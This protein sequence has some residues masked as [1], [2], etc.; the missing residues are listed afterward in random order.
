MKV[1]ELFGIYSFSQVHQMISTIQGRLK[2][3]LGWTQMIASTFPMG[4]MT[5]APKKRVLELIE[6]YEKSKR[7]LFSGAVGYVKPDQDFDFNV[8][9]RSLLY[10][11]PERYLSYFAGSGITAKSDPEKEYEECLMKV[12]AIEKILKNLAGTRRRGQ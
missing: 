7:G 3:G 10:N 5:G 8:V 1:E 12:S 9:I 2:E 4:S 11:K 6:K